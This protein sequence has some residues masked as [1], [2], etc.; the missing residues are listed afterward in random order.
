MSILIH[1]SA[2]RRVYEIPEEELKTLTSSQQLE[3]SKKEFEHL[4][5][6]QGSWSLTEIHEYRKTKT[7]NKT[8]HDLVV[9]LEG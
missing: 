4:C 6:G 9:S 1:M 8:T 5:D 2:E 7:L 3:I